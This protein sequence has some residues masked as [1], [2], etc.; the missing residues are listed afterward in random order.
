MGIPGIPIGA[1]SVELRNDLRIRLGNPSTSEISN[2][3]LDR[4]LVG[5]L[6]NVNHRC[7]RQNMSYFPT[8]AG[9]QNYSLPSG[10][11]PIEVWPPTETGWGVGLPSEL[12]PNIDELAGL[13]LFNNPALL[14]GYYQKVSMYSSLFGSDWDWVANQVMILPCPEENGSRVY[15]TYI[16]DW[17]W[18]TLE[19]WS[20]EMVL[21]WGQIIGLGFFRNRQGKGKFR[22]VSSRGVS[23]SMDL[24]Q[25]DTDIRELKDQFEEFVAGNLVIPIERK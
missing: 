11:T 22:S 13:D 20:K 10:R 7:P 21:I 24:R 1:V 12:G 3:D 25:I 4:I 23:V 17:V 15:Y 2:S 14:I 19:N 6:R 8:V 16:Y 9:T 18:T 5:A